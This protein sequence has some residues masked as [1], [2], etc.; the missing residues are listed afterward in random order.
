MRRKTSRL[1][2]CACAVAWPKA[3]LGRELE[4]IG[5]LFSFEKHLVTVSITAERIQKLTLAVKELL[6][7]KGLTH[8]K[9]L[10]TLAGQLSWM[11]GC[12]RR[13]KPF[14][15]MLWAAFFALPEGQNLQATNVDRMVCC[16]QNE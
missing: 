8:D 13:L 10:R 1:W 11:S 14:T 2:Q 7:C 16:L 9:K 15:A 12:L 6:E 5:V 3:K 4:W